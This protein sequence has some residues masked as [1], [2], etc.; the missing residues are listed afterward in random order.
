MIK[1]RKIICSP[2]NIL[3]SAISKIRTL[4]IKKAITIPLN[5]TQKALHRMT[6]G[7]EGWGGAD[8]CTDTQ[9]RML[10][11]DKLQSAVGGDA[12]RRQIGAVP[13]VVLLQLGEYVL[14]IRVFA[15]H[16][17]V[18]TDLVDEQFALRRIGDVDHTLHHVVGKLVFHHCVQ[19]RLRPTDNTHVMPL[20]TGVHKAILLSNKF[21]HA[22]CEQT[23]MTSSSSFLTVHH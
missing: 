1:Q 14:A 7:G 5:H 20:H 9:R 11:R 3:I 15:E 10:T 13:H 6:I 21:T 22:V 4:N 2:I 19:C 23:Q 8:T 17:D 12:D 18:R 16:S